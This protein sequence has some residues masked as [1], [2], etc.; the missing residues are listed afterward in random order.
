MVVVVVVVMMM[1]KR[2]ARKGV[3]AAAFRESEAG[4]WGAWG[5]L[6]VVAVYIEGEMLN[7]LEWTFMQKSEERSIKCKERGKITSWR[8]TEIL[9]DHIHTTTSL[10]STNPTL[11]P[12][13][14]HNTAIQIY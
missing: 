12:Y 9:C 5:R 13:T 2:V 3:R 4:D 11:Y 7:E 10:T 8:D 1:M 14:H 6:D